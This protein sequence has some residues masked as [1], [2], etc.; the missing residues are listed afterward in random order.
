MDEAK[1]TFF[2]KA[3]AETIEQ[4]VTTVEVEEV[5]YSKAAVNHYP[6]LAVTKFKIFSMILLGM[7][8]S[9]H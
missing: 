4:T 6:M 8:F 7:E 2:I 3:H 5:T 9:T 1:N